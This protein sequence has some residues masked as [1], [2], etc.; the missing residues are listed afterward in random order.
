MLRLAGASCGRWEE[1]DDL[2]MTATAAAAS[3][4]QAAVRT[5]YL[6][7]KS[8]QDDETL[9]Q[10]RPGSV[11]KFCGDKAHTLMEKCGE[12]EACPCALENTKATNPAST[13]GLARHHRGSKGVEVRVRVRV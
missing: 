11:W 1:V 5:K 7:N 2:W 13:V 10:W 9:Q 12:L 6:T 8:Q 3:R 4:S